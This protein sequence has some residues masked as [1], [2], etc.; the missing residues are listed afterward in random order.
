MT[1]FDR[2]LEELKKRRDELKLK[3]H[4][5]SKDAQDQWAALE[6]KWETFA[7]EA[8]LEESASEIGAAARALGNEL[9]TGYE[10]IRDALK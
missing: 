2:L 6:D 3:I 8:R 5:G 4:L 10:K 1:D 7:T 9:K